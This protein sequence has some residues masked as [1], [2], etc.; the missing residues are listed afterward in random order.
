[1][2]AFQ[3]LPKKPILQISNSVTVATHCVKFLIT[4]PVSNVSLIHQSLL[5]QCIGIT[6]ITDPLYSKLLG[7]VLQKN[8]RAAP[9]LIYN[10]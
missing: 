10:N 7:C 4:N 2:N 8:F 1:M 9:K 3:I 6:R 5:K